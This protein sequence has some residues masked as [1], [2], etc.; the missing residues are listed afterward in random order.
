M[1]EA[2]VG[3]VIIGPLN[4]NNNLHNI[5]KGLEEIR[6]TFF[7]GKLPMSERTENMRSGG[8]KHL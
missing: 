2:K 7:F 4:N 5:L 3:T 8:V 1:Y 6:Q